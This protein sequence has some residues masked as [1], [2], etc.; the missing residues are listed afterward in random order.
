MSKKVTSHNQS[1]GITSHNVNI[2]S[3][4]LKAPKKKKGLLGIIVTSVGIIAGSVAILTYF[5]LVPGGH[6]MARDDEGTINIT[7][8]DQRGGITAY[9]VNIG[10]QDRKLT[11]QL[12]DQLISYIKDKSIEEITI[13]AVLGDQEA[14][15]F[16]TIIKNFLKDNGY[17]VDGVNQAVYSQPVQGQIIEPSKDGERINIIIC[18][19]Q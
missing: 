17:S 16:A 1:G 7:S 18:D 3:S 6:E 13:T 9:N 4:V 11:P 5:G 8:H 19:R 10:P 2:N 14:F 12:A 15:Q